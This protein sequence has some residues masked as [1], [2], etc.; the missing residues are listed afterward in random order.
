MIPSVKSIFKAV[1]AA[2]ANGARFLTRPAFKDSLGNQRAEMIV[3]VVDSPGVK[4]DR[5][6]RTIGEKKREAEFAKCISG[7]SIA[8]FREYAKKHRPTITPP[9]MAIGDIRFATND[10]QRGQLLS[11]NGDRTSD[12]A[13]PARES[14]AGRKDEDARRRAELSGRLVGTLPWKL[15]VLD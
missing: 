1:A 13:R 9:I 6:S 8:D 5:S 2:I 11:V 12:R 7:M 14:T 10:G 4:T 3:P 15:P